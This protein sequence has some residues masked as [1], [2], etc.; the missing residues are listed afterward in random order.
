MQSVL[1]RL[2]RTGT[3]S[4]RRR[5]I[6][7]FALLLIGNVVT[8]IWAWEELRHFPLLLGTRYR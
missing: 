2:A 1:K 5:I 4:L 7:A 6:A 3:A 8:W